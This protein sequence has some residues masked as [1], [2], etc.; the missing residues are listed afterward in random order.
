MGARLWSR[1]AEVRTNGR[2]MAK[3]H[4]ALHGSNLSVYV[5]KGKPKPAF[6]YFGAQWTDD[7]RRRPVPIRKS[8]RISM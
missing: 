3:S 1:R 7:L 2:T 6:F 8:N 5:F 4:G